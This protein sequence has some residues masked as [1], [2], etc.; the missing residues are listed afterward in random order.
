MNILICGSRG[1]LCKTLADRLSRDKHEVYYL[2]GNKSEEKLSP[3]V[4]QEYNF[5]YLSGNTDLIFNSAKPDTVI[6]CGAADAAF[7]GKNR[8]ED[9][10]EFITKMTCL[11]MAARNSGTKRLV[12]ISSTSVFEGN[13]ENLLSSSVEPIAKSD[14]AETL[15]R[16]EKMLL[17]FASKESEMEIIV[18]RLPLVFGDKT[19]NME[20]DICMR[21]ALAYIGNGE[22]HIH[23]DNMHM[24]MHYRD[25]AAAVISCVNQPRG[26]KYRLFQLKGLVFSEIMLAN[27]ILESGWHADGSIV[28]D[29][30]DVSVETAEPAELR[31][32]SDEDEQKLRFG[33][34]YNIKEAASMLC[35]ECLKIDPVSNENNKRD[36]NLLPIIES[37]IFAVITYI[38]TYWLNGSWVGD[39]VNLFIIYV[40]VFAT[41]YGTSHGLLA[42]ILSSVSMLLL[43]SGEST[44]IDAICDYRLYLTCWLYIIVGVIAGFAKDKYKRKLRKLTEDNMYL[45][46]EVND[47]NLINDNNVYIK[48]TYEKRLI[49]YKNS[50]SRVYEL[51]TGMDFVEPKQVTFEAVHMVSELL[52]MN[53]VA[54]YT[55]APNS[56][57]L[58][59]S[60]STGGIADSCGK[61]IKLD[62]NSFLHESICSKNIYVNRDLTKGRPVFASAVYMNELPISVIMVWTKDLRRV[63]MHSG[64]MLALSC[65]LIEKAMARALEYENSL[66]RGETK[67]ILGTNEF[68]KML[69]I[70]EGARIQHLVQY[71]VIRIEVKGHSGTDVADRL[72]ETDYLGKVKGKYFAILSNT[73]QA[74]IEIVKERFETFGMSAI[75]VNADELLKK[76]AA[77]V[78]A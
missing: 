63:N 21:C 25:A 62:E 41:C 49:G 46:N 12:Y 5:S 44:F 3:N 61:S 1:G 64:D 29:S 32:V 71:A 13:D 28:N 70:Y 36:I 38:A 35:K 37:I 53:S 39:G 75:E 24:A 72:R 58:R 16:V 45:T 11:V 66:H 30:E 33:I 20:N 27:A 52:E 9:S 73:D 48:N 68:F 4:F 54:V 23:P 55:L 8:N 19:G 50:I 2:S 15:V 57:Y 47:L 17:D 60:A 7:Y 18:L 42:S 56:N 34:K 51:I 43:M 14:K 78:N 31:V 59:L 40:L 69:D 77:I 6:V 22:I 65:R 26:E 10:T 76:K 67:A 74:G